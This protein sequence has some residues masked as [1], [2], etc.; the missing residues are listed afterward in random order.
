MFN[1]AREVAEDLVVFFSNSSKYSRV[2]GK[3]VVC[4]L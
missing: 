1:G 4:I 2:D 3:I